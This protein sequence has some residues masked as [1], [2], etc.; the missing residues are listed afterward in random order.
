MLF[1][2]IRRVFDF[3]IKNLPE[4]LLLSISM[5]KPDCGNLM[6]D[7]LLSILMPIFLGNHDNSAVVLAQL[8]ENNQSLFIRGI[9]ELCKHDQR[10]MNLSRV[11]D[12]TQEIKTS[13]IK[14]VYSDDYNFAVN[15]GVLAGK[16]DFLHYEVWIKSRIKD[17][18]SPFINALVKYINEN[19]IIPVNTFITQNQQMAEQ[20]PEGFEQQKNTILEKSHL[21]KEKL[22]QTI[23]H[24]QNN[25]LRQN[26]KVSRETIAKIND[27]VVKSQDLFP[28]H[29]EPGQNSEEIEAAA[30][31]HFQ[32][33]FSAE[34]KD[35][36]QRID[37][38][39]QTMQNFKESQIVKEQEI[40]ACMLHGLFDEYRF[41]HRYPPQYLT[42]IAKL[43]GAIIKNNLLDRV[44]QDIALKFVYEAFR[45]DNRRQK[46]GIIV[47]KSF[48]DVLPRFPAF[49]L[50]IYNIRQSIQNTEPQMM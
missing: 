27:L 40:F 29:Y 39:I 21:S 22:I 3:P 19:I 46:F 34:E 30:N 18:G 13:L 24:L 45:R 28:Q 43:F 32:R 26:E 9:C 35:V 23:E 1:K 33:V 25:Q 14:I 36:D 4:Y 48:F 7:E 5:S 11:L 44:L 41:L 47:I 31:E 16:R 2:R 42:K 49:L 20:N 12:I 15:L 38:L 8:F 37:E 10:L 17:V 6:L 50:D